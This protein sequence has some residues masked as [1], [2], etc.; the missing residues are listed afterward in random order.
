MFY[1]ILQIANY[2]HDLAVAIVASNIFVV[3]ILGRSIEKHSE[4]AVILA[5]TFRKLSKITYIALAYILAGGALRAYYFMD[6]EWIPAAGK[7]QIAALIV[8]HFILVS[9]TVWGIVVHYRYVSKYG[10]TEKK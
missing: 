8:K 1:I 9:L 5:E 4:R 7:G 10:R 2:F 3:Y 6:F